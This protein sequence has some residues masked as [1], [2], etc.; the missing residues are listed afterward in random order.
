MQHRAILGLVNALTREH[1]LDRGGNSGLLRELYQE[2]ARRAVEMILRV[3]EKQVVRFQAEAF[4]AL[5]VAREQLTQRAVTHILAIMLGQAFPGGKIG[6]IT[7]RKFS[8]GVGVG[9]WVRS[10]S[11]L[12]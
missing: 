3:V 8:I 7:G 12:Y 2:F 1:G 6:G 10:Y 11:V 4:N 9:Q 5:F